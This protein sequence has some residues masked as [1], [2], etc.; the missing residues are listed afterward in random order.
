MRPLFLT[1]K[2][3]EKGIHFIGVGCQE[4]V[5]GTLDDG[6]AAASN[7]ALERAGASF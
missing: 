6:E 3:D 2:V 1:Q 4:A 7:G 5:R